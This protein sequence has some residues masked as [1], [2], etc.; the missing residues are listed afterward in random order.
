MVLSRTAIVVFFAV[1][2]GVFQA[3]TFIITLMFG[4]SHSSV[5]TE[6]ME[7]GNGDF[8]TCLVPLGIGFLDSGRFFRLNV[9]FPLYFPFVQVP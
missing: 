9:F 4:D 2:A 7:E 5:Y 1:A 3:A 6:S 8:K